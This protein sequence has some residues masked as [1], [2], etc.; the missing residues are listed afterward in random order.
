MPLFSRAGIEDFYEE[1]SVWTRYYCGPLL[2]GLA[3][4]WRALVGWLNGQ[5][6]SISSTALQLWEMGQVVWLNWVRPAIEEGVRT[7]LKMATRIGIQGE[8]WVTM[9]AH[10][11]LAGCLTALACIERQAPTGTVILPR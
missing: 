10:C 2:V 7:Q 11:A 3:R 8:E 4:G 1:Y 6:G 5:R 9:L